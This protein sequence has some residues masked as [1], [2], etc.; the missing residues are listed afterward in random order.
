MEQLGGLDAMFLSCETPTMHMHVCGLLIL[1]IATMGPGDPF[2]RIAAMLE[3]TLARNC[4]D[5]PPPVYGAPEPG[6]AVLD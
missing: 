3:A 5:A 1:D 6:T 4:P 2:D